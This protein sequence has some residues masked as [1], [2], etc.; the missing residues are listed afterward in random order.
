[1]EVYY[2]S[3]FKKQYQSLPQKVRNQFKKRLA[4]FFED[5]IDPQ[6]HVHKLRGK[7]EGLYSINITG[8]MRAV[9][10]SSYKNSILFIAIG[11]HSTLYS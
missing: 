5:Q 10:D 7:Y 6:L 3:R 4:L 2:S 11:T 8:D 1:M 9:F